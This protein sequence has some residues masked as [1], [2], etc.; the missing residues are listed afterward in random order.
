MIKFI[1]ITTHNSIPG[2]SLFRGYPVKLIT[3]KPFLLYILLLGMLAGC[4]NEEPQAEEVAPASETL[5]NFTASQIESASITIGKAEEQLLHETLRL[6]GVIDVPPSNT[7]SIS[8]PFGGYLKSMNLL[9]G[10]PVKKGQVL[11]VIEDKEIVQIQQ[12]YLVARSKL[13]YANLDYDRQKSLNEAKANSNKVF[14]QARMEKQT[15]EV[16]VKSLAEKLRLAGI[17]P[18]NLTESSISRRVNVLSPV[19]GFVSKVNVNTGRYIQPTDVLFELIDP[20]HIHASLTVFEKDLV[21]IR[22]GQK[23]FISLV[24]EPEKEYTSE[25]FEITKGVDENRAGSIHCHFE[26]L[27]VNVR[28]GM[29]VNARINLNERKSLAV[30]EDAL[31][32]YQ[33][34]EFLFVK[35]SASAFEMMPVQTGFRQEGMVE[36]LQPSEEIKNDS[37]ILTNAFTALM[38]LKNVSE[39]E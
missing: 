14:E 39:E 12:D 11:A 6:N 32:R 4:S 18:A 22:K 19:N 23:A 1:P 15:Q 10:T 13:E 34:K 7:V 31:V 3:M 36:I 30:P 9:P 25:V 17:N 29:F 38:K 2:L 26:R 27:P 21:R 20:S 16:L 5:V 35:R 28:P 33:G 37:L 8:F 24:E